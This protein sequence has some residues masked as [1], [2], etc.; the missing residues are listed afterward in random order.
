MVG[1][2]NNAPPQLSPQAPVFA[3]QEN[4]LSNH[5]NGLAPRTNSWREA[6]RPSSSNRHPSWRDETDDNSFPSDEK[7]ETGGRYHNY[8][9]KEQRTIFM[10]GLSDRTTHADIV[11]VVK[12][13]ALLDVFLRPRDRM[14]SVSFVEPS[15]AQAFLNYAKRNDIYLNGKRVSLVASSLP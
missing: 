9:T 3:P 1:G 11:N 12:G 10:K 15:A 8:E 14:A 5:S 6:R 4:S 7:D 13:G 2:E